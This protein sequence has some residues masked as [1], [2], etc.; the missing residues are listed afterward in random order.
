KVF[1]HTSLDASGESVGLP[2]GQMGNSEVGHLNIGAGRVVY[3]ELTRINK[4]IENMDFFRNDA[5]NSAIDNAKRDNRNLHIMGLLSDGG[6]HSHINHLKALIDLAVQEKVK[7]IYIHAFLDG[8]DVPPRS[9]IPYLE[10]IDKYLKDKSTGEIATVSGR[11]YSM[12]RDNRW[13]R[14]KRAYDVLVYRRGE[15]FDSPQALV[16]KSYKDQVDDEFVVPALVRIKNGKNGK[17]KTGDS[18]IF[19]NFRPDR[20]RQLTRAFIEPDFSRF[21]RGENPPETYFVCMT[22]YDKNYNCQVA[23]PPQVIDNTLGEVLSANGLHQLRIAETEKYAHVTFFFNG[24]IEKPYRGEDRILI[25]SPDVATYNLKP[26]MSAI[27]VTDKV[28]ESIRKN[29]YDII[30]LNYANADMVGHTGFIDSAIKAVETVDSCVGKVVSE[31]N[32]AGGITI[33]T[34]DHGN[35]EE[36][37]SPLSGGIMTAHSTFPVPFIVCSRE[38]K[39]RANKKAYKLSDIAPTLLKL[40]ELKKPPGMTGISII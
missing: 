18:V 12:D 23:F 29:I 7:N 6:V 2:E 28:I 37:V 5:L 4:K 40:L 10:D 24:G 36:M 13:D 15:E 20:A 38:F 39:I 8:R 27:E 25:P 26:E 32:G 1:P 19:F 31:V 35:A 33:I 30:I 14:T 17:I 34:A 11:Y 9:A 3:Q 21:D 16:E 22:Q